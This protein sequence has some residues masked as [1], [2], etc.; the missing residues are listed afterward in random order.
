MAAFSSKANYLINVPFNIIEEDRQHFY[1]N[2]CFPSLSKC[3]YTH[4]NQFSVNPRQT[5]NIQHT[6]FPLSLC[7]NP[8]NFSS[9]QMVCEPST[10]GT[11]HVRSPVHAYTH[12][13]CKP[14]ANGLWTISFTCVCWPLH[15]GSA[16]RVGV[17]YS[18]HDVH[19][20][21]LL[22]TQ[23]TGVDAAL[24]RWH[25]CSYLAPRTFAFH[26]VSRYFPFQWLSSLPTRLS[27]GAGS[28]YL[29]LK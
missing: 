15:S 7:K 23:F 24:G 9:Q 22:Y 26:A 14:F 2:T 4:G 27:E 13:V 19:F 20:P 11:A 21:V 16:C 17:T 25:N 12:L 28:F 6:Q 18:M 3:Q 5:Q 1:S 10:D 29:F 8:T